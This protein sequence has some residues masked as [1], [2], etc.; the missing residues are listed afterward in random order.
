MPKSIRRNE[1]RLSRGHKKR[2]RTHSQLIT[3]GLTVLADK[4]EALT[5]SDVVEEAGVSNG[6][7]YNYFADRDE[8]IEALAEA[9]LMAIAARSAIQTT[10]EDPAHRFAVATAAI[11]ARAAE[12]PT[13]GRVVLRLTDHERSLQH[14]VQRYLREDLA[15][16]FEQGRFST[17][18]D[19]VTLDLI[20]GLVTMTIRRIIRGEAPSGHVGRVLERALTALGVSAS[21]A[22]K[23][24]S[25]VMPSQ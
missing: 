16:G 1:D 24:V 21:E 13:W 11:L 10:E 4:G 18:P 23:V 3:A 14:E 17:G 2:E 22:A 12:D 5:V 15:M 19:E 6:T 9:S 25:D 7:F 20:M 8:L